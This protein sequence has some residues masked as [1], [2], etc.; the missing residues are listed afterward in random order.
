MTPLLGLTNKE[1]TFLQW[2]EQITEAT[3]PSLGLIGTDEHGRDRKSESSF[4]NFCFK[5]NCTSKKQRKDI[6]NF[7]NRDV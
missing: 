2:E 3:P 5:Y 6:P 1:P 7:T 4:K